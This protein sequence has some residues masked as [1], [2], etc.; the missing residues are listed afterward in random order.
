MAI[1]RLA[2]RGTFH[3]RQRASK[4][5][6]IPVRIADPEFPVAVLRPETILEH[7][8]AEFLRARMC[9]VKI[10]ELEPED[11]AVARRKGRITERT[12]IMLDLPFVQL[13]NEPVAGFE[14][15][16]FLAAMPAG[17]SKQLLVPTACRWHVADA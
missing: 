6:G 5:H 15:F 7:V 9:I 11:H 17:A 1:V 4:N 13:K 12:M 8:D 2:R 10:V 14:S 3:S 16:I